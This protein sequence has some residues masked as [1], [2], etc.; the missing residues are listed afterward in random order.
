MSLSYS[1]TRIFLYS[2]DLLSGFLWRILFYCLFSST[3]L[4]W[5]LLASTPLSNLLVNCSEGFFKQRK[6]MITV[7]F[8]LLAHR[9]DHSFHLGL[10]PPPAN[11]RP[12]CAHM[13]LLRHGPRIPSGSHIHLSFGLLGTTAGQ[14]VCRGRGPF[15][16]C[17]WIFKF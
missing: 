15:V 4:L 6:G 17:I 5:L 1:K 9:D 13:C 7:A 8:F 3:L 2:V 10:P 11:M 16:T 12:A 14:S